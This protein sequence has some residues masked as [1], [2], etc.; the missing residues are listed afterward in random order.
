MCVKR[1]GIIIAGY[2]GT[3]KTTLAKNIKMSLI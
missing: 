1:K 2:S 3:G